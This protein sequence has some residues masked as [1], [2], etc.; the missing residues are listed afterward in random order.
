MKSYLLVE[1]RSDLESPD[2]G[3]LRGLAARLRKAGHDVVLFLVQNGVM[4]SGARPPL[5]EVAGAGVTVWLDEF[6]VRARGLAS[7]PRPPGAQVVGMGEL[8]RLLMAPDVI[9][10]WH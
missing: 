2:V 4:T 7:A 9:A 10:L 8:V 5:D 6:S 1:S 3:A